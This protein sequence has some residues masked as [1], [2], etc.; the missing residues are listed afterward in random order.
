M[1]NKI[2][3]LRITTRCCKL[4]NLMTQSSES[5]MGLYIKTGQLL[6]FYKMSTINLNMKANLYV[7]KSKDELLFQNFFPLTECD[8]TDKFLVSNSDMARHLET[9]TGHRHSET[10]EASRTRSNIL[11]LLTS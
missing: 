3:C 6:Q 9:K 4:L 11:L 7:K 8:V 5:T 2:F 1:H 10:R